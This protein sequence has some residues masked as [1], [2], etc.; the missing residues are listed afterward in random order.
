[1]KFIS[2]II[3]KDK[4]FVFEAPLDTRLFRKLTRDG[5]ILSADF[6]V[7]TTVPSLPY[8]QGTDMSL[9]I[10]VSD[11]NIYTSAILFVGYDDCDKHF[12]PY[13]EDGMV[14]FSVE[15]TEDEK[16]KILLLFLKK[17]FMK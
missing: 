7:A 13:E 10:E 15:L 6:D 8:F 14:S 12:R 1:M 16:R 9:F 5:D 11:E 17:Y 3:K 2:T 4:P